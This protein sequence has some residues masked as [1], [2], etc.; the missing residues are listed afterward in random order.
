[1]LPEAR[2]NKE[3]SIEFPEIS[4]Q[5]PPL[6]PIRSLLPP[7]GSL[8]R[9]FPFSGN[10]SPWRSPLELSLWL[11]FQASHPNA[12]SWILWPESAP[13]H[14]GSQPLSVPKPK[15]TLY[16]HHSAVQPLSLCLTIPWGIQRIP[17]HWQLPFH[18]TARRETGL[19][20]SNLP[21]LGGPVLG[22]GAC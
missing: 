1:M 7:K 9:S 11:L 14:S 22:E 3:P 5:N 4:C 6:E 19:P 20:P 2:V 17:S 13:G 10:P 18:F 16:P 15:W 8:S 12:L 21:Q